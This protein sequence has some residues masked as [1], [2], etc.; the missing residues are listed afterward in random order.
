MFFWFIGTAVVAVSYVFRDPAFDYRLLM[1][2]AVLP[3]LIDG[4]FGGARVFHSLTA[5]VV[6]LTVVMLGTS[7]RKR[8]RRLLLPL[9]IGTF[10]H[11]VFD[12]AWSNSTVFWWPFLGTSFEDAPLPTVERGW[13]SLVLEVIGIGIVWWLWRTRN[14]GDR[15]VRHEFLHTGRLAAPSSARAPL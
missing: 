12:G 5:S 2:G 7:R 15:A 14:L 8:L 3:D 11:L 1:V 4:A 9:P 6:L 13:W 10:L